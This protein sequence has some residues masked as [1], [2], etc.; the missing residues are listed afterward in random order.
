M[1]A[2][3]EA[4]KKIIIEGRHEVR[5]P[6]CNAPSTFPPVGNAGSAGFRRWECGARVG[7]PECK[8]T[9]AQVVVF[10]GT[11]DAGNPRAWASIVDKA[12]KED[13]PSRGWLHPGAGSRASNC[14]AM[15]AGT[16]GGC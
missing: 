15:R 8:R 10:D 12:T 3:D 9:R 6:S 13:Q 16:E 11:L 5:S 2:S 4:L 1:E 14:K 7:E